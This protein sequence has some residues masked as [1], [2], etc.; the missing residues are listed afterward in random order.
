MSTRK[1]AGRSKSNSGSK[2]NDWKGARVA[3]HFRELSGEQFEKLMLGLLGADCW[4][5]GLE[6]GDF[7]SELAGNKG[8]GG[9]DALVRRAPPAPTKWVKRASVFQAKL[10]CPARAVMA[11]ELKKAGV[12]AALK[13][14]H[15]YVLVTGASMGSERSQALAAL[16]RSVY[17]AWQGSAL[18]L[19]EAELVDWL[20][21]YPSVWSLMPEH[22]RPN[23]LVRSFDNWEEFLVERDRVELLPAFIETPERLQVFDRIRRSLAHSVHIEGSPGVGKTRCVLEAFRARPEVVAYSPSFNES[24][25][26]LPTEPG[27]SLYGWLVVDECNE[28]QRGQ[29]ETRFAN[30]PLR[31]VT[32]AADLVS[33]QYAPRPNAVRLEVLE[34]AQL[35]QVAESLGPDLPVEERA[36]LV[37]LSG[38]Y[39]KLLRVLLFARER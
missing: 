22:Q 17:P 4:V 5:A 37:A 36:R 6:A 9:V 20:R 3:K 29:L 11:K 32:I 15:D 19:G 35:A 39:V 38:G 8:D 12:A 34:G 25:L 26:E 28:A 13:N 7:H 14:G 18:V 2:K 24:L 21:V 33:A 16:I 23:R 27:R 30:S 10:S 1:N 31:L